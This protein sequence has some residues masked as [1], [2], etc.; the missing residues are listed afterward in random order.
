MVRSPNLVCD[1]Q[2]TDENILRLAD[3]E[4]ALRTHYGIST[5]TFMGFFHKLVD[6]YSF[7]IS[8]AEFEVEIP[9]EDRKRKGFYPANRDYFD[10][11]I[12]SNLLEQRGVDIANLVRQ[13]VPG[14]D[15]RE[16]RHASALAVLAY[17]YSKY[18]SVSKLL[19]GCF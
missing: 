6:N 4:F 18:G 19:F 7:R 9:Y 17:I 14:E 10:F 13:S 3:L 12:Y 1:F 16:V 2:A 5:S 15:Y 11:I 8:K